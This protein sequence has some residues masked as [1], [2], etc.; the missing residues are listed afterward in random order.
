MYSFSRNVTFVTSI[1]ELTSFET[2]LQET[3]QNCNYTKRAEQG[4]AIARILSTLKAM[5]YRLPRSVARY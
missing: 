4:M 1:H 2:S 5:D 3:L